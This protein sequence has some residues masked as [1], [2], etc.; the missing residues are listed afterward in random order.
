MR[1]AASGLRPSLCWRR[2]SLGDFVCR[3]AFPEGGWARW[4][5]TA[6]KQ[7]MRRL[8]VCLF[9]F[10]RVGQPGCKNKSPSVAKLTG[11]FWIFSQW[12]S[13]TKWKHFYLFFMFIHSYEMLLPSYL[14]MKLFCST[15]WYCFSFLC[16]RALL[17]MSYIHDNE[18]SS[19][20]LLLTICT[21]SM[22]Y[23]IYI[24]PQLLLTHIPVLDGLFW[25]ILSYFQP[26][27]PIN[28]GHRD[29]F[30]LLLLHLVSVASCKP[31]WAG[32]LSACL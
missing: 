5:S 16:H 7:L 23:V 11:A 27:N 8:R 13:G 29:V 14:F 32:S 9:F 21:E 18:R 15:I 3:C 25:I 24:T 26:I 20:S 22:Y 31:A 1:T 10:C 12:N 17:C 30:V 28:L 2:V 6:K 19:Y 4:S